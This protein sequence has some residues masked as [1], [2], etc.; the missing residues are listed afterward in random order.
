VN[1][2]ELPAL[3]LGAKVTFSQ[4]LLLRVQT[5]GTATFSVDD[6]DCANSTLVISAGTS[7]LLLKVMVV[8]SVL[9]TELGDKLK[10]GHSK[11][12]GS[13]MLLALLAVIVKVLV[14]ESLGSPDG[15]GAGTTFNVGLT[16]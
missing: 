13:V 14:L 6:T 2:Q 9:L 4:L 15:V 5:E 7:L 11:V 12:K 3:P 10:L 1:V 8:A 16:A